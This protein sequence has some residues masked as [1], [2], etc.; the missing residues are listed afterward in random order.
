[1]FRFQVEL[2]GDVVFSGNEGGAVVM[3]QTK[4]NVNGNVTFERNSAMT[5]G[6]VTLEDESFVC[7][8]SFQLFAKMHTNL[9][10]LCIAAESIQWCRGV[11][12]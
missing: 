10:H 9:L 8:F 7:T 4:M 5:G 3:F 12:S 1:M 2:V 6:A 11:V